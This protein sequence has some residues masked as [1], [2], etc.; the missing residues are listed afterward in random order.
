[1]PWRGD[2]IV[3]RDWPDGWRGGGYLPWLPID[4]A[5]I[6]MVEVS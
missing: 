6:E 4:E 3:G 1:M 2:R 5:Q